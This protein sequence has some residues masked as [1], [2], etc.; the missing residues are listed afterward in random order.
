MN[1]RI[2]TKDYWDDYIYQIYNGEDSPGIWIDGCHYVLRNTYT[3]LFFDG[4]SLGI[5][6]N[7]ECK[8]WLQF[9]TGTGYFLAAR[10]RESCEVIGY[11]YSENAVKLLEGRGIIAR[12]VDL[13]S[14]DQQSSSLSYQDQLSLDLMK[15][16]NLV[17]IRMLEYLEPDAKMLFIHLLIEKSQ[18]GS[19]FFLSESRVKQSDEECSDHHSGYIKTFFTTRTDFEPLFFARA[20]DEDSRKKLPMVNGIL[21]LPR[22]DVCVIDDHIMVFK[23]L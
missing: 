23:K 17:A 5:H 10:K 19:V 7:N 20:R 21:P 6:K 16:C 13:N 12:E 3:D 1:G 22:K 2:E 15:P 8:R 11:D 14:I 4:F 18:P 9:G